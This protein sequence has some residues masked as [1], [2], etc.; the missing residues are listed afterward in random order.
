[1]SLLQA[2]EKVDQVWNLD[3]LLQ[4]ELEEEEII[5]SFTESHL[6]YR[7][8]HSK[9]GSI[10][11]ALNPSGK[12]SKAGFYGQADLVA[13]H[14]RE[15]GARSVLEMGCG[16]GFN[17]LYLAGKYPEVSFHGI[18]LTPRHIMLAKKSATQARLNDVEFQTGN[19]STLPYRSESFD[20]VFAVETL[21]YSKYKPKSLME[22]QRVMGKG[23]RFVIVDGFRTDEFARL[24][25][26]VQTAAALAEKSMAVQEFA[27]LS[28]FLTM[29]E[30]SGFKVLAAEDRTAD[31]MPTVYRLA[32]KARTYYWSP[33]LS[34]WINTLLPEAMLKNSVAALLMPHT[35][36]CGAHSYQA[37][38]LES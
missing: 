10:H 11:M 28:E 23:K 9:A 31:I 1:M 3:R 27:V 36:Q 15:T 16:K 24:D 6:A 34:R 38:V 2:L 8:V 20:L 30:M 37:I 18:D 13:R 17:T 14:I 19:F 7:W 22:A 4:Q 35:I 25:E 33:A 26:D 12:F 5:K 29:A 32:R 21:C